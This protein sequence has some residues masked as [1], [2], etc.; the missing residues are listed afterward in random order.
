MQVTFG[1]LSAAG[2]HN[3]NHH[4]EQQAAIKTVF[5]YRTWR[6]KGS[7]AVIA[8]SGLGG[9]PRYKVHCAPI[10][11]TLSHHPELNHLFLQSGCPPRDTQ[12]HMSRK[13]ATRTLPYTMRQGRAK[14]PGQSLIVEESV[15]S[16]KD[17]SGRTDTQRRKATSLASK[18]GKATTSKVKAHEIED[19][20]F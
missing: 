14:P 11:S 18:F 10:S 13:S 16:M 3:P 15:A 12:H 8:E 7:S 5:C 17:P 2:S 20:Y 6:V 19:V 1:I 4:V 9:L